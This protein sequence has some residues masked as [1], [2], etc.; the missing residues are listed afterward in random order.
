LDYAWVEDWGQLVVIDYKYGA[1]VPVLPVE[2]DGEENS[3]LMYYAAGICNKVGY[4]FESVKLV[5]I[6][7]RVWSEGESPVS[8]HETTIERIQKFENKVRDAIKIASRPNAP[9]CAG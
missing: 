6:Q 3:Q 8:V 7:P 2:D 4:D 9:L 5:V 1:G